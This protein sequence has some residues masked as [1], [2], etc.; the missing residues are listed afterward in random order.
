MVMTSAIAIRSIHFDP[1]RFSTS[2]VR[3]WLIGAAEIESGLAGGLLADSTARG[4]FSSA[5]SGFSPRS[6]RRRGVE[7]GEPILLLEVVGLEGLL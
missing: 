7:G 4:V 6:E 3:S 5:P 1:E 2:G